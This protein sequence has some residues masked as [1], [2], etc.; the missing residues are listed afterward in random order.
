MEDISWW[1]VAALVV[2]GAAGYW[3]GKLSMLNDIIKAVVEE[4]EAEQAGE[5]PSIEG[6][7]VIEKHSDTYYAYIGQLFAGQATTFIELVTQIKANKTI[8]SFTLDKKTA[9]EVLNEQERAALVS[10]LVDVYGEA[11]Q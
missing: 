4:H 7:L 9:N 11:K 8:G 3:A 1:T 5:I 2:V 10:A 6:D